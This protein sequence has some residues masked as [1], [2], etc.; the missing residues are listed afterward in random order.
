MSIKILNIKM[1]NEKKK[2]GSAIGSVV[3]VGCAFI[4]AGIGKLFEHS[5]SGLAI[6]IGIGFLAMGVIWA[7]YRN[8]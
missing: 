7:Y 2:S 3:L 1:E 5:K 4:G 6:G 8:K